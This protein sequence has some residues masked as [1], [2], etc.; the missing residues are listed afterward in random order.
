MT[1]DSDVGL[2]VEISGFLIELI[3][4]ISAVGLLN[5]T[6]MQRDGGDHGSDS[7]KPE[8]CHRIAFPGR[9]DDLRYQGTGNWPAKK[10]EMFSLR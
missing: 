5:A 7:Q 10:R 9:S 6:I 8:W 1:M 3:L 4:K 2:G